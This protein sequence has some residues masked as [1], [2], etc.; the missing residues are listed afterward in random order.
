MAK[1]DITLS[2]EAFGTLAEELKGFYVPTEDGKGYELEGIGSIQRA[3]EAEKLKKTTKPELLTELEELKKFKAEQEAKATEAA[4]KDLEAK[5]KYEEALTAKEKAWNDRFESEKVEK[6]SLF[7]DIKRERLTNELVKRGA[8]ADRAGYL[9]GEL[10][11]AT[12]LV[13]GE[14]GKFQL[15]KKGGIGDAAEFDSVIEAAKQKTPFFFAADGASGSGASGSQNNNGGGAKT[16][17]KSQ[18]DTLSHKDQAA[19]INSGGNVA[20]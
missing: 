5:G 15:R 12:E 13:K 10:D 8:L 7:A 20:E 1:L 11:T 16:M 17:P 14:D 19:H 2:N 3:L 18:W 4:N 9:V 6:E